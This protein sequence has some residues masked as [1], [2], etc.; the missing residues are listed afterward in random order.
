M[1]YHNVLKGFHDVMKQ[2]A[3]QVAQRSKSRNDSASR[4]TVGIGDRVVTDHLRDW[5]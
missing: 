4:A 2:V 3:Q 5:R 1:M